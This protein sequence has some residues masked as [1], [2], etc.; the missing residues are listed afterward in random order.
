M[1][2][3]SKALKILT[4]LTVASA[5]LVACDD[6]A[7]EGLGDATHDAFFAV[8]SSN[9]TGASSISLLG[10]DGSVVDAEWVGSATDNPD[11]RTPFSEDVVLATTGPSRRY[12][13]VLERSLGVVTRF[14]LDEGTVIGQLRT[15]SSPANDEAAYHS[16]PQDV[17]FMA[18]SAWISRWQPNPDPGADEAEGGND[19]IE[20]DVETWERGEGRIDLS[21]LDET[22]ME[23]VYD[24][25][26]EVIDMVEATAAA[27][28]A[29]L[30]RTGD[31]IA[32]GLTRITA[33]YTY[34]PGALAI[35]DPASGEITDTLDLPP[36][37]NCGDIVPVAGN[38]MR[39]LVP[40][41]GDYAFL[42]P[43]TGLTLVEVNADGKAEIVE[44]YLVADHDGAAATGQYPVSLG[45]T[46]VLA[47]ASGS[48]DLD[49]G[50]A[51]TFDTMYVID[52]ASGDQEQ[53]FESDGAFS[54]GAPSFDPDT[55]LVLVPD[56]G[57]MEEPSIGLRSFQLGDDGDLAEGDF[58]EVAADSGLAARQV[59]KL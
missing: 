22:V 34:G 55:G 6:E 23:P 31:F 47:V 32:V 39:V 52:L 16:N 7:G 18:D 11:L 4:L 40:C 30:V 15:D 49:T 56:A 1:T 36:L 38:A 50:A 19:L 48:L 46:R 51:L 41:V 43:E 20:V 57:D 54:I 12:L 5:L 28:P 25:N 13:T 33:S 59:V 58:I 21:S 8:V 3:D 26:F 29:R 17:V 44:S 9:Y 27:S 35:V 42:G 2:T 24:E 53:L 37:K 10:E 45:G 14:D